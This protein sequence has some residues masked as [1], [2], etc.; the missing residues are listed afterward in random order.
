MK[1]TSTTLEDVAREAGVSAATISRCLNHPKRVREEVREKVSQAIAKLNYVPHGAARAL[2][3]RKTHT[4]GAVVPTIDHSI[5]SESI[6]SLQKGLTEANYTLLIANSAYSL[7]QELREVQILLS[8]GID[9][10]V[11][12]GE[13][14][15]PGIYDAIV[16]QKIAYVSLW[17]YN[18]KSKYSCIGFNNR[19]AGKNLAQHLLNLGH[20][21]FGV[22]TAQLANN[23][24]VQQ[25]L[26]G[27]KAY[28]KKNGGK[29]NSN[30]VIE[31]HYSVEQGRQA[32]H[33]LI[34]SN[35]RITAIVCSNDV[36]AL[37]VL[38]GARELKIKVPEEL[39][40]TGFDNME[41]TTALSPALT[42][43]NSPS[44][45]MGA[46]AAQYLISEIE[47]PDHE[48]KR[49]ELSAELIVR[50]T[51]GPAGN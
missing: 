46:H 17:T 33:T 20:S 16:S 6:Q 43:V 21:E 38:W 36:L 1:P 13:K 42:T 32:L 25:R 23:D 34:S 15:H 47:S 29:L 11:L 35:S 45:K 4:I 14:H 39:S 24:R 30:C 48:I 10:L 31:C 12:V 18:R 19:E 22:V 44:K 50:D 49:I 8:R 5:F 3:S 7:E 37:G 2:A 26:S 27:V 40:V 41:L 51:T 9:G 28:L